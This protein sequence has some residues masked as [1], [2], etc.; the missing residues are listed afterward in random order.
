MFP[1]DVLRLVHAYFDV[2]VDI[3]W[4]TVQD[5][6]PALIAALEPLIHGRNA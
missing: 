6:P 5:D 4:R 1:S 3:L 2:N